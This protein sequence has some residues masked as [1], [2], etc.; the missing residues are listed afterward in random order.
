MGIIWEGFLTSSASLVVIGRFLF[1]FL[2]LQCSS[3]LV[4]NKNYS[5]SVGPQNCCLT[6]QQD[7]LFGSAFWICKKNLRGHPRRPRLS[8]FLRKKTSHGEA[9]VE[10]VERQWIYLETRM[11][12]HRKDSKNM[13]KSSNDSFLN[14]TV[15]MKQVNVPHRDTSVTI[16]RFIHAKI[17]SPVYLLKLRN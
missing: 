14:S 10:A 17:E 15:T 3:S 8:D 16:S 6:K 4:V 9:T 2:F 7:L 11:F 5:S 1:L 13:L 12:D